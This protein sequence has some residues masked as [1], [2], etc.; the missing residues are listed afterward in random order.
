MVQPTFIFKDVSSIPD[1]QLDQNNQTFREQRISHKGPLKE[2]Q[3]ISIHPSN[4][5]SEV[6]SQNQYIIGVVVGF[7][8]A[9]TAGLSLVLA[10]K[11]K[12]CPNQVLMIV[13]G[14]STFLVGLL[15]PLFNLENRFLKSSDTWESSVEGIS[16]TN[17]L[18]YTSGASLL[19]LLGVFVLIYASQ[20]AP[21]T[22]V[23]T[24]RSCEILLALFVEKIVFGGF[25]GRGP[26]GKVQSMAWLSLGALLVLCSAVFMTLSDWIEKILCSSKSSGG[27]KNTKTEVINDRQIDDDNDAF[28]LPSV[29]TTITT[30]GDCEDLKQPLHTVQEILERV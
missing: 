11:A 14:F 24:I 7:A 16:L 23:S 8:T 26:E 20:V 29:Q 10:S 9:F 12:R 5:V 30:I 25:I 15:G 17:D 28:I 18:L 1:A 4:L 22:L 21:P 27:F 3:K 19:S 2:Y 6:E 13:V